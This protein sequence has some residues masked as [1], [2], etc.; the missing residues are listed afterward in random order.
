MLSLPP[1]EYNELN[2]DL[3]S[4]IEWGVNSESALPAIKSYGKFWYS[5]VYK[6]MLTKN[7]LDT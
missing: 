4:Y 3:R 7:R 1:I 6:Q 5:H 2:K